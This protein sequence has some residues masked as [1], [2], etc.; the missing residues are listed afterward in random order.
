MVLILHSVY[1]LFLCVSDRLAAAASFLSFFSPWVFSLSV[2]PLP[3]QGPW[4]IWV[5]ICDIYGIC[6]SGIT[7][8]SLC[9]WVVGVFLSSFSYSS[10]APLVHPFAHGKV[11]AVSSPQSSCEKTVTSLLLEWHLS[12]YK[13]FPQ[14]L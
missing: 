7:T 3:S 13:M 9:D 4:V 2:V 14:T 5:Q 6:V 10:C 12:V 11:C 1:H 8:V